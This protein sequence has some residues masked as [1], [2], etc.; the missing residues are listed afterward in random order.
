MINYVKSL[1]DMFL[2]GD[3]VFD[4]L[5]LAVKEA[6]I[7]DSEKT[8]AVFNHIVNA[9]LI[10]LERVRD[11]V[12]VSNFDSV[13]PIV[14]LVERQHSGTSAWCKWL[15]EGGEGRLEQMCSYVSLRGDRF[16]NKIYHIAQH[17][18]NHTTHHFREVSAHIREAGQ[19][20]PQTDFIAYIR[21]NPS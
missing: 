14:D 4:R 18:I 8:V 12:A 15:E 21:L 19:V 1:T 7:E 6:G 17:V 20:P 5:Y 3:W 11:G 2:Y 10:W 16:E 9:R 13:V